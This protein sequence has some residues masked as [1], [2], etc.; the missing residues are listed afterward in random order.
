MIPDQR[1]E[2]VLSLLRESPVLSVKELT[3]MLRVSHMTVRRDI[4]V[5]EREGRAYSVPGGVR[6][7]SPVHAE[8]SRLDKSVADLPQ[9][10]AMAEAALSYVE[11]D[12]TIY[13]DA[14]TTMLAMVPR[15]IT[16]QGLT[17]VTNDFSTLDALVGAKNVTVLHTGGALEHQNRSAVG[18]LAAQTLSHLNIDRAF[19]SASS[20][21]LNRGVT[22]PSEPKVDVKRAAIGAAAECL[23]VA[24]S[25]K[26]GTFSTHRVAALSEFHTI[27]TDDGLTTAAA[28]GIRDR[29]NRLVIGRSS[30]SEDSSGEAAE[31][32]P[33]S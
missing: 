27:V 10:R 24:G 7:A 21:D 31:A 26:Y 9:K 18:R 29:G 23:L 25:R 14:G 19:L 33:V 16:R 4:E 28:D 11:D 5:L 6:L 12:M 17:V 13:L 15:L 32:A 22:T 3:D 30:G 20:W 8:P 1:R 2:Q